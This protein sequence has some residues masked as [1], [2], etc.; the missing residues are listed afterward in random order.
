MH[1]LNYPW[2]ARN[3]FGRDQQLQTSTNGTI[4]QEQKK[5]SAVEPFS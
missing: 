2:P 1:S 4:L 3:H 5:K